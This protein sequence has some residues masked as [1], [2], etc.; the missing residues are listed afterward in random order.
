VG[1]HSNRLQAGQRY[2]TKVGRYR[3]HLRNYPL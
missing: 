3:E 2:V 1:I